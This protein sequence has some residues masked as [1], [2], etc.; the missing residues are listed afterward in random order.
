MRDAGRT[1]HELGGRRQL[2]PKFAA[3]LPHRA[4]PRSSPRPLGAAAEET[5]AS[6]DSLRDEPPSTFLDRVFANEIDGAVAAA[7]A[8]YERLMFREALKAGW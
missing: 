2:R 1:K 5:L 6:A 3:R 8:A 7:R 4:P